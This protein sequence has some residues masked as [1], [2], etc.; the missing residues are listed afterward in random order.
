MNYGYPPELTDYKIPAHWDKGFASTTYHCGKTYEYFRHHDDRDRKKDIFTSIYGSYESGIPQ[1]LNEHATDTFPFFL[2][3]DGCS[4]NNLKKLIVYFTRYLNTQYFPQPI[5]QPFFMESPCPEGSLL[6]DPFLCLI[7]LCRKGRGASAHCI[8]PNIICNRNI[9]SNIVDRVVD[10]ISDP[11]LTRCVDTGVYRT[12]SLRMLFC[13]KW[14]RDD[15]CP[16]KRPFL[17]DLL[18]SVNGDIVTFLEGDDFFKPF[19]IEAARREVAGWGPIEA[20][21]AMSLRRPG[22]D[23]TH[24]RRL[25]RVQRSFEQRYI[26]QDAEIDDHWLMSELPFLSYDELV[27]RLP[28]ERSED[29]VKE[30]VT[31]YLNQ[32]I[33]AI[34]MCGERV[35]YGMRVEDETGRRL[36]KKNR[37]GM[38]EIF[39]AWR[40]TVDMPDGFYKRRRNEDVARPKPPKRVQKTAFD[41]WCKCINRRRYTNTRCVPP[42]IHEDYS[43]RPGQLNTYKGYATSPESWELDKEYSLD[44][45]SGRVYNLDLWLDFVFNVLCGSKQESFEYFINWLALVIQRPG[46][47]TGVA[48]VLIGAEGIGKDRSLAIVL[49]KAF[50]PHYG[51]LNSLNSV[52]GQYTDGLADKCVALFDELPDTMNAE[53]LGRLK[54]IITDPMQYC[55]EKFKRDEY[56]PGFL[57]IIFTSNVQKKLFDVGEQA[58]RWHFLPVNSRIATKE[59]RHEFFEFFTEWLET[60]G[61]G[62]ILHYLYTKNIEGW[63]W[64][65]VPVTD[66]LINMKMQTL[67]PW[68]LYWVEAIEHQNLAP[69]VEDSTEEWNVPGLDFPKEYALNKLFALYQSWC[70]ANNHKYYGTKLHLRE[71]AEVLGCKMTRTYSRN[72]TAVSYTVTLPPLS[73]AV[74]NILLAIKGVELHTSEEVKLRLLEGSQQP[75]WEGWTPLD[76]TLDMN[77]EDSQM[78]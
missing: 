65:A 54:A 59:T 57:N 62:S 47:K 31:E 28:E 76:S 71:M 52:V 78:F 26:P 2:D 49:K 72:E 37:T 44:F 63:N 29:E 75:V 46:L 12:C 74:A 16:E 35:E 21:L 64:R 73:E 22:E 4:Y 3:I 15:R 13:D 30:A 6:R 23:L 55:N 56:K 7:A 40:V 27:A 11:E 1:F 53:Q 43:L 58:R 69:H 42:F 24:K 33:C 39:E 10:K 48:Q 36:C 66:P 8:W 70:Q 32:F 51:N 9:V 17:P 41:L 34:E 77:V 67:P 25:M 61:A 38:G 45:G 14:N 68:K 19:Q 5:D 20:M 50:G 60:G 18:C